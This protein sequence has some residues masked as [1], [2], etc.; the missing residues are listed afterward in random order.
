MRN[1]RQKRRALKKKAAV[2]DMNEIALNKTLRIKSSALLVQEIPRQGGA[3][4][5]P[6]SHYRATHSRENLVI[7]CPKCNIS[8]QN[9]CLK[10]GQNAARRNNVSILVIMA[11]AVQA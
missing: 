7:A 4:M 6:R 8:K 3:V 11:L 2:G 5:R 1:A 10:N 9:K